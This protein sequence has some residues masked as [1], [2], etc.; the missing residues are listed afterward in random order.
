MGTQACNPGFKLEAGLYSQTLPQN[1]KG[2]WKGKGKWGGGGGD[3][4]F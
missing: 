4:T 1:P 3:D 2:E